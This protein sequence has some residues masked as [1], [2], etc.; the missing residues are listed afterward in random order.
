MKKIAFLLGSLNGAGAEKT[1]ITL[2]KH[3]QKLG[4][5]VYLLVLDDAGDYT[6]P[7]DI[8]LIKVNGETKK[9][10]R[11][12]IAAITT[13]LDLDLFVSSRGEF[14][15]SAIAKNKFCSVHITPTA[16]IR[17]PKWKFWSIIRKKRKLAKK[18]SAK[19][20]IALSE[21]IRDDLIENLK[22]KPENI[23]TIN[24]PFEI[25]EIRSLS[26]QDG[27]IPEKPYA[28]YVASLIPR[29]RHRDLLEA[30]SRI[31]DKKIRLVF[32]G[33]GELQNE[34]ETLANDLDLSQ[35]VEFLGWHSNPYKL[36][37]NS[38]LSLLTSEAEGLPRVLVES[39][40]LDVPVVSTDCPSGP[41]EVMTGPLKE[42]LVPVGDVQQL[43]TKINRALKCY[44]DRMEFNIERFNAENVAKRYMALIK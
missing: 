41:S 3:L 16:W 31:E 29:K 9:E 2:C 39:L 4:N 1:I 44:P 7:Q 26:L 18:F 5:M 34:L 13:R 36:I 35:R 19:N 11:N 30:F 27:D 42:Y 43:A 21:G 6:L 32:A 22:C 10:L 24:N 37:K 23:I 38:D 20:L 40:I 15:D 33:K 28:I 14:Y 12:S 8:T 17:D 25:E